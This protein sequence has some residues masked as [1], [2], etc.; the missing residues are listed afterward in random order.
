M[1]ACSNNPGLLVKLEEYAKSQEEEVTKHEDRWCAECVTSVI[2]NDK[3]GK[4]GS[5][6]A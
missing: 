4:D 5:A 6:W 1:I 2:G 3:G